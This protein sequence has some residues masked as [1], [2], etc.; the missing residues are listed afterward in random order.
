[1]GIRALGKNPTEAELKEAFKGVGT[2]PLDP[3]WLPSPPAPDP[4][5]SRLPHCCH[6]L[7]FLTLLDDNVD[8]ATFKSFY[9]KKFPSPQSQDKDARN[10]FKLLDAENNGTIPESELRQMLATVGDALTHQEVLS[11]PAPPPLPSPS[12]LP[13]PSR[14]LALVFSFCF[15]FSL[16]VHSPSCFPKR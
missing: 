1:M 7:L 2:A 10:A 3:H 13:F 12:P 16:V 5:C 9:E 4:P 15:S 8:F 6:L 14:W 11:A